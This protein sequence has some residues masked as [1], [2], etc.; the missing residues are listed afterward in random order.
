MIA[1]NLDTFLNNINEFNINADIPENIYNFIETTAQFGT[2]YSVDGNKVI[3][4]NDTLSLVN[5]ESGYAVPIDSTIL[6]HI[7]DYYHTTAD[8]VEKMEN[9]T[10]QPPSEKYEKIFNKEYAEK[11][12]VSYTYPKFINDIKEELKD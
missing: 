12:L 5:F 6:R 3:I 8:I 1:N 2:M 7:G 9:I 10:N 11:L 4:P